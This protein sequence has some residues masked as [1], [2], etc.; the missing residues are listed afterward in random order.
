[1]RWRGLGL[2]RLTL[3]RNWHLR[4]V[5]KKLPTKRA[6]YPERQIEGKKSETLTRIEEAAVT[7]GK[8]GEGLKNIAAQ[9]TRR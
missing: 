5:A 8:L 7:A 4:I 1:M 6:P 2:F 3:I 9:G